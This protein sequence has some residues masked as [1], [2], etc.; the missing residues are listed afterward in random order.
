G[1][2]PVFSK[3]GVPPPPVSALLPK[4]FSNVAKNDQS[5]ADTVDATDDAP[6]VVS[7]D[8]TVTFAPGAV[9]PVTAVEVAASVLPFAGAVIATLSAPGGPCVTYRRVVNCGVSR[10]RRVAC[11][12]ISRSSWAWAQ[13]S[14]DADPAAFP[15]A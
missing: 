5:G 6:L 12:R 11:A 3:P 9:V 10:L 14:G 8:D 1:A 4:P 13:V 2:Y 7:T 15:S